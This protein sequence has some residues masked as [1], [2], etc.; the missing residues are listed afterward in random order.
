[1]PFKEPYLEGLWY[2]I[3]VAGV[4]LLIGLLYI[5]E[6]GSGKRSN[7]LMNHVRAYAGILWIALGLLAGWYLVAEQALPKFR[8]GAGED[9]I[10]AIIYTFILAPIITGG[11]LAFGYLALKRE[12][13]K[14]D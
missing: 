4:S 13:E 7:P 1:L 9:L 3:I 11:L 5:R 6:A 14:E 10:P 12:Y 2:P 8:S